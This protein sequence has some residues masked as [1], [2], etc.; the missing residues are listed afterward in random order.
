M[1]NDSLGDMLTRI[2][3]AAAVG[4]SAVAV[5]ASKLNERVAEI[6]KEEGYLDAYQVV[7]VD[8]K[9]M[10]NLTLRYSGER[11]SRKPVIT[12]LQRVSRPG[13]RIYVPKAEIPR[14]LS[15]IG[16]AILST[17]K[18]VITDNQARRL[19]VGGEVLCYVY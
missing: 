4:H 12:G 3:N 7:E 13:K 15:G 10:L 11:R 18:G 9:K 6:L 2:R 14:V 8:G 16:V 19:G 1:A 17:P 5:R